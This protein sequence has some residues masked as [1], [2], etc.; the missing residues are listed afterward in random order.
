[1]FFITGKAD[2]AVSQ[3]IA[4][5][6]FGILFGLGTPWLIKTLVRGKDAIR[7]T[8]F[9][10]LISCFENLIIAALVI[11]VFKWKK[12]ELGRKL[13]FVMIGG[14]ALYLICSIVVE[15]KLYLFQRPPYCKIS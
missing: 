11:I 1:M 13:G 9:G 14:Y 4:S 8:S 15:V 2:M 12:F 3:S 5:N 6:T 7:I 10:M